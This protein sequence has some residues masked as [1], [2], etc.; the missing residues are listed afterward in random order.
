MADIELPPPLPM[1]Q[2][3]IARDFEEW[4]DVD[5]FP[6]YKIS[7]LGRVMGLRKILKPW[8]LG[9]Y[10]SFKFR[11]PDGKKV[12]KYAHSLLLEAFVGPR[13]E[14]FVCRHKNGVRTHCVLSNLTWGTYAENEADRKLHGTDNGG[15]ANGQAKLTW[16][17]VREIR[18][19][20]R[21]RKRNFRRDIAQKY[22]V[23]VKTIQQIISGKHW[24]EKTT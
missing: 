5:G 20:Y 1:G 22:G 14:G 8:M 24:I 18:R 3:S 6:P 7:N 11:G 13:P 21:P 19:T 2:P 17:Q 10:P 12:Q 16:E 15:E 4:R 23:D 9:G